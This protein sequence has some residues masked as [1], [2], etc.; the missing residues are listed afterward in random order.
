M[1]RKRRLMKFIVVPHGHGSATRSFEIS[2]TRL[3]VAV[4]V[5]LLM[6]AVWVG[7]IVSWAFVGARAARVSGLEDEVGRLQT[8]LMQV[9]ELAGSLR[10][11]ET[12]YTRMRD[13]LGAN[14][15]SDPTSI[16]I[17]AI[18][19]PSLSDTAADSSTALVPTSWPLTQRGYITQEH[20]G[21]I[22]GEHPGIDIAV[23]EG[24]YIRAS[25]GGVVTEAGEDQIYGKYVRIR[26]ADGYETVYGHASDL[27]VT[28]DDEVARHQV[29]ALTGNTGSSTAPHLHFEVWKDGVPVD[30]RSV[31]SVP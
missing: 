31:V 29:I 16:W 12:Q 1:E 11:L 18:D 14:R 25:G 3:N 21:K 2:Y 26:H 5:V 9:Q 28:R 17:P 7:T 23:P 22:P 10:R 13:V 24:N 27:F 30:P 20:L 8:E 4:L 6:G 15:P 19:G